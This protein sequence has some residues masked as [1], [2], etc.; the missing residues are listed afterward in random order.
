MA[1]TDYT[2]DKTV[3]RI[4]DGLENIASALEKLANRQ[5]NIINVVVMPDATADEVEKRIEETLK[6]VQAREAK[7]RG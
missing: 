4:G 3:G 6:R 7:L 1:L 2:F 5:T